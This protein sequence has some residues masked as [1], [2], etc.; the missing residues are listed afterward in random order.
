MKMLCNLALKFRFRFW[1]K[2]I[3]GEENVIADALSRFY[4]LNEDWNLSPS[5]TECTQQVLDC[6]QPWA[7]KVNPMITAHIS[8]LDNLC[9]C[10]EEKLCAKQAEWLQDIFDKA[11]VAKARFSDSKTD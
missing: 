8:A 5:P 10:L 7:S 1:I 4:P 11:C 6:L 2:H 9:E 3:P